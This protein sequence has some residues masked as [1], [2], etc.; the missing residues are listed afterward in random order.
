MTDFW[1]IK[2][3]FKFFF[4]IH[5]SFARKSLYQSMNKTGT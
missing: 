2:E 4:W 5:I 1:T 3:F